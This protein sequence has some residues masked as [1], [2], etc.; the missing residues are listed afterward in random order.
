MDADLT[1]KCPHCGRK[2][3]TSYS[4][5]PQWGLYSCPVGQHQWEVS[6]DPET[7]KLELK[8]YVDGTA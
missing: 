6:W 1:L 3:R 8:G 5:T 2:L 4:S 7:G